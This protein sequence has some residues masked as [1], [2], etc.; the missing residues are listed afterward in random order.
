MAWLNP[1]KLPLNG[2][3]RMKLVAIG[4]ANAFLEFPR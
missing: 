4:A 3:K 2:G 1:A